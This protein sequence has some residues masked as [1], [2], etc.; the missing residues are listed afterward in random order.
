MD[1]RPD[2][3]TSIDKIVLKYALKNGVAGYWNSNY[4]NAFTHSHT[5]IHA[6]SEQLNTYELLCD[7]RKYYFDS[8]SKKT[9]YSFLYPCSYFN[10][11][12]IKAFFANDLHLIS[13]GKDSLYKTPDFY[14][15]SNN[16]VVMKTIWRLV[17][18]ITFD[19]ESS[20]NNGIIYSKHDSL[21]VGNAVIQSISHTGKSCFNLSGIEYG[22]ILVTDTLHLGETILYSCWIYPAKTDSI[23]L[24]AD[25][26]KDWRSTS[27]ID[28]I[29][30][31]GWG[32]FVIR[33]NIRDEFAGTS[34]KIFLWNLKKKDYMVDDVELSVVK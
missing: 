10:N 27:V 29:D 30:S 5:S 33:I 11:A 26:K 4:Y 6:T 34:F 19:F 9:I 15:D 24:I 28:T 21:N 12:F 14:F 25:N 32:R 16:G 13:N 7:K 18:Q 3:V 23:I 17:K 8:Q 31:R 1:Y 20:I 2:N 22:P